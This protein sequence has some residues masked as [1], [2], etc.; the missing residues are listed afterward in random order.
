M[1]LDNIPVGRWLGPDLCRDRQ[2]L[3]ESPSF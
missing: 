3:H 1:R 2:R